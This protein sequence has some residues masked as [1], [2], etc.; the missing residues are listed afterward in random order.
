[1]LEDIAI[2]LLIG[3]IAGILAGML[4]IGSGVFVVPALAFVFGREHFPP[5]LI[6][7]VAAGTSLATIA[8]TTTRALLSHLKRKIPFWFVYKRLFPGVIVGVVA[9]AVLAHFLHS[10]TLSIIFGVIIFLLGLKM[11]F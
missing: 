8:V 10:H 2:Y 11:F 5:A 1:M 3:I 7:H 4:G 9:G 6:M